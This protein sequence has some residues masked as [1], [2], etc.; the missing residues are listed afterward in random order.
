MV[1]EAPRSVRHS[2]HLSYRK[3]IGE[4]SA[5]LMT[6]TA[7]CHE[8]TLAFRANRLVGPLGSDAERGVL[9]GDDL[10]IG[11]KRSRSAQDLNHP[12]WDLEI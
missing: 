12:V 7:L 10:F 4:T 8:G 6:R 1:G 9:E 11:K 2:A 5:S 3:A